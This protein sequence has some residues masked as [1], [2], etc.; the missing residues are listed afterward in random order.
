MVPRNLRLAVTRAA[1]GKD[2]RLVQLLR[3]PQFQGPVI[4]YCSRQFHTETVCAL[5]MCER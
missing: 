5:D 4:V 1:R 2:E 3:L